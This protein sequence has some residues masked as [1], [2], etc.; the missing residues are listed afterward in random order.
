[1]KICV[2]YNVPNTSIKYTKWHDGFTQAISIL[3][4][5]FHI[6]MINSFDNPNIDFNKYSFVFFKESFNGNIYNKYKSKLVKNN[7]LGLFISSSNIIPSNSDLKLYNILFYETKWYYNY[8]RLN[9]HSNVYHA[10]GI[11]NDVMKP[12]IEEKIYD[13]IFVGNIINYKRPLKILDIPGRKICLGF[14]G[15]TS[16][17]NKLLENDV[18]IVEFIEY[19]KLV[20]YYNKSKLCYIPCSIHGGGERAVLEARSCGIPVKIENDNPKLKELCESEIYSSLYYSKQ[21]EK[22]IYSFMYKDIINNEYSNILKKLQNFKLN[23]LEVGGM[24]GKTFDPLYN[25]ISSNWNV[26]ILEPIKYQFDKLTQNYR[27]R[28]N[29]RLINKALNYTNEDFKMN[30]I[31]PEFLENN[32]VPEWANG[33]SSFYKDR[34]SIGENYWLDR[35]KVHLSKGISFNTIKDA[36][37]ETEVKCMTIE[38]LNYDRIDIL[39]SDTEGF[40]Y[41]I[42]KMVLSKH[43]P[44]VIFFEWNNL[45]EDELNSVKKLLIN[46]DI[47]FYKQDALCVLKEL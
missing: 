5:T 8:A 12:N 44:Y 24:D 35:G 1:M 19:N 17:I 21:I 47:R 18:E 14:K 6:D 29:V 26:T 37:I 30:T 33:I 25:N 28:P 41:N 20:D 10:F 31:K 45:P 7:I 36:I 43:K 27:N 11:D 22:A 9:R 15:D 42:I 38:E 32:Q 23:I 4:K 46:Y 40:D 13:V 2:L 39:Q 16:I 3:R 34:N